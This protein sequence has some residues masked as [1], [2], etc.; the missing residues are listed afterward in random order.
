M[1][2]MTRQEKLLWHTVTIIF[3]VLTGYSPLARADIVQKAENWFASVTTMRADFTQIASD[4]SASEGKIVMRRP[5]RLKTGLKA[6]ELKN[7]AACGPVR[8]RPCETEAGC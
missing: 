2:T 5:S 7:G 3:L 8:V 1:T 6:I 4:G